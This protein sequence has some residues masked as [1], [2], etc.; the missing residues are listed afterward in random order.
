MQRGSKRFVMTASTTV[1]SAQVTTMSEFHAGN[2]RPVQALN[3]RD[4]SLDST[5]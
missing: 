3:G 2:N 5:P 1:S 4:L